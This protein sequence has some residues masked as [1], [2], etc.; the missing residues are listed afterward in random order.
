M[1]YLS[2]TAFKNRTETIKK[3]SN[4]WEHLHVNNPFSFD[5][6][7]YF[8]FFPPAPEV[9]TPV[10]FSAR[11]IVQ[12]PI[13]LSFYHTASQE[14][15]LSTWRPGWCA[16]ILTSSITLWL[17][18]ISDHQHAS[19]FW[20]PSLQGAPT[21]NADN[22]VWYQYGKIQRSDCPDLKAVYV[23]NESTVFKKVLSPRQHLNHIL[24]A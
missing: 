6:L 5:S 2:H 3:V 18:S 17:V 15:Y 14:R 1:P 19:L 9:I 20:S 13:D 7:F 24:P 16:K 8:Y 23:A 4:L 21:E 11:T 22:T 10:F 12:S